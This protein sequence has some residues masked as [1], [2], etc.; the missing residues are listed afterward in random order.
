MVNFIASG[1]GV[2]KRGSKN[3]KPEGMS[4]YSQKPILYRNLKE[5]IGM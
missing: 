5:K 1:Y 3:T 4:I 2:V